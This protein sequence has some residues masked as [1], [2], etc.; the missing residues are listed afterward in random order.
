MDQA[1]F[2]GP[3][4]CALSADSSIIGTCLR[5]DRSCPSGPQQHRKRVLVSKPGCMYL[6]DGDS[7]PLRCPN[8]DCGVQRRISVVFRYPVNSMH[9]CTCCRAISELHHTTANDIGVDPGTREELHRLLNNLQQLLVGISIM[10]ASSRGQSPG[11]SQPVRLWTCCWSANDAGTQNTH[12]T[13]LAS[14][15]LDAA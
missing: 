2:G 12:S 10:Q 14:A 3:G 1:A 13:L 4:C 11:S 7:E 8:S 9:G 6:C 15:R 5:S